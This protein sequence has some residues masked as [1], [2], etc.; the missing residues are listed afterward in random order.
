MNRIKKI[1]NESLF[2]DDSI[3]IIEFEF[4]DLQPPEASKEFESLKPELDQLGVTTSVLYP[5][6]RK[7]SVICPHSKAQEV[8]DLTERRGFVWIKELF[9]DPNNPPQKDDVTNVRNRT[10]SGGFGSGFNRSWGF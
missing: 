6:V 3:G 2:N 8:R 10:G 4:G 9:D 7:V 1:I 5:A